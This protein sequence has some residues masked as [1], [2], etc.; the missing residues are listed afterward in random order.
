MRRSAPG[1]QV[2]PSPFAQ[3]CWGVERQKQP[4]RVSIILI[5]QVEVLPSFKDDKEVQVERVAEIYETATCSGFH[6]VVGIW[7]LQQLGT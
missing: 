5:N 7:Q 6:S 1:V 4:A 2:R 3:W